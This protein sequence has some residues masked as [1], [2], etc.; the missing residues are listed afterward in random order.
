MQQGAQVG[1]CKCLRLEVSRPMAGLSNGLHALCC[2]FG[3]AQVSLVVSSR[4]H[5]LKLF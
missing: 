4:A 3:V 5:T 2:V 1:Q